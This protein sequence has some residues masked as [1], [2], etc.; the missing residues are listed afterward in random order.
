MRRPRRAAPAD[1][2]RGSGALT[3]NH[4]HDSGALTLMMAAMMILLMAVAGLVIDGG[5]MLD[6]EQNAYSIAEEAARAGAGMVN[7]GEAYGSGT[8]AVDGPQALAAAQAYL[9]TSGYNGTVSVSGNTIK[10]TVKVTEH[11]SVLSL[12]GIDTL[13]STGTA[14]ASL[15]TSVT[16]PTA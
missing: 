10:V 4:E 1:H 14:V 8:Y 9:A 3:V 7:T 6:A 11:T 15:V 13:T 2:E 12:V 5:R 16:G